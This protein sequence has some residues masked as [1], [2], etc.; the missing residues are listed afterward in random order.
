VRKDLNTGAETE[1][2]DRH[3]DS[4]SLPGLAPLRS[5]QAN[6]GGSARTER[7]E[8][9]WRDIQWVDFTS[10]PDSAAAP[11]APD[12]VVPAVPANRP[13]M[14]RGAP[15]LG[16]ALKHFARPTATP[17]DRREAIPGL[18]TRFTRIPVSQLPQVNP[19]ARS[20]ALNPEPRRVPTPVTPSDPASPPP[21]RKL[22]PVIVRPRLP[23]APPGA[24]PKSRRAQ[25]RPA[26]GTASDATV[27]SAFSGVDFDAGV[28]PSAGCAPAGVRVAGG[29]RQARPRGHTAA[30][31]KRVGCG[32]PRPR[33]A[34]AFNS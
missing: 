15:G 13:R 19:T 9:R 21:A 14:R 29:I 3:A 8:P 10:D 5:R 17:G 33:H 34:V 12:P 27:G 24:A 1:S 25:L 11:P 18:A 22:E 23:D 30:R 7:G 4:T 26:G 28:G 20:V 2:P 32:G 16:G 6:V 31:C